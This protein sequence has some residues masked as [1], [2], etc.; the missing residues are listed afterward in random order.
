M[1]IEIEPPTSVLPSRRKVMECATWIGAGLV[2]T[3]AGGVPTTLAM[4]GDASGA[5]SRFSF[6]Q[7]SDSHI[8]FKA[9]LILTCRAR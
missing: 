7:I 4:I 5:T 3:F 6:L 1:T 8:G 9:P 2:W